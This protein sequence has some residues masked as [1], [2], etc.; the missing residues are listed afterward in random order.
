VL[1]A[2]KTDSDRLKELCSNLA[3]TVKKA[4]GSEFADV[5]TEINDINFRMGHTSGLVTVAKALGLDEHE[6]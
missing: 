1:D 5:S 3:N 6:R 4:G 2:I